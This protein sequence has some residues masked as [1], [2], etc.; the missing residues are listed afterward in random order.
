[1]KCHKSR[2]NTKKLSTTNDRYLLGEF[3][4]VMSNTSNALYE[5]GSVDSILTVIDKPKLVDYLKVYYQANNE[6]ELVEK[7]YADWRFAVPSE[8][9]VD[10]ISVPRSPKVMLENDPLWFDINQ[11]NDRMQAIVNERWKNRKKK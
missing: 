7:C 2:S 3:D 6:A 1:M 8:I 4:I 5:G 11:L 9:S 10:G